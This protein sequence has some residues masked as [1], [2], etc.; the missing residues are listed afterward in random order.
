ML[1]SVLLEI[2]VVLIGFEIPEFITPRGYEMPLGVNAI[3]AAAAGLIAQYFI[4]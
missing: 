3:F 1:Q 4:F 2:G